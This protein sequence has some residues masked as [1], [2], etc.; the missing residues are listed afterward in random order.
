MPETENNQLDSCF[1]ELGKAQ[2]GAG[3]VEEDNQGCALQNVAGD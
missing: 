1:D 3:D 2:K